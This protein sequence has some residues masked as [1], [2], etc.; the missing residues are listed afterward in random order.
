MMI[1]P[2]RD[3]DQT[4]ISNVP[5]NA[6]NCNFCL[7]TLSLAVSLV[8]L[9]QSRFVPVTTAHSLALWTALSGQ[10]T[11]CSV[12]LAVCS[13]SNTDSAK[14]ATSSAGPQSDLK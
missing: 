12:S 4:L 13:G 14:R 1:F 9:R 5:S 10:V 8:Q 11:I 6:K 3:I 2:V 7:K